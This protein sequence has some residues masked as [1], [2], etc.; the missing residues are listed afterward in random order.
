MANTCSSRMF[1][2][3]RKKDST[4]A[5]FSSKASLTIKLQLAST[6]PGIAHSN[7]QQTCC[8]SSSHLPREHLCF[9]LIGDW[10]NVT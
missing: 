8:E 10:H 9:W 1:T 2:R 4:L 3:G 7:K 6:S 5:S